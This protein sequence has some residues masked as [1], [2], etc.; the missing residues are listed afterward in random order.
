MDAFTNDST[1]TFLKQYRDNNIRIFNNKYQ[2]RIGKTIKILYDLD[3]GSEAIKREDFTNIN[4]TWS[5]LDC[6][7][8]T[9]TVEANISFEIPNH[10]NAII[11]INKI[12][13]CY[14]LDT[15]SVETYN[16]AEYQSRLSVK[17]FPKI[18][19][20]LVSNTGASLE[21]ISAE[22]TIANKKIV[23]NIIKAVEKNI[24]GSDAELIAN[25]PD[26]TS[27]D[28]EILKQISTRSFNNNMILQ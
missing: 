19:S 9:S 22:G 15:S 6:V 11:E 17:Y 23:S 25:A 13:D 1:I 16:E 28:A 7:I 14:A 27:D 8:Y 10:F 21:V 12:A 3:K 2:P 26:I 18:L 24:K 4:A 5:S 20:S